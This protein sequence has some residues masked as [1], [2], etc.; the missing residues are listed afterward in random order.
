MFLPLEQ[1]SGD[2]LLSGLFLGAF[3]GF[4]VVMHCSGLTNSGFFVFLLFLLD[5]DEDFLDWPELFDL[6]E[7]EVDLE[8]DV[9]GGGLGGFPGGGFVDI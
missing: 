2:L 1:V 7:A 9:G 5:D 8:R 3:G 6:A 4:L